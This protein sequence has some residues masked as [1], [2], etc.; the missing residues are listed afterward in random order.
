MELGPDARREEEK[1]TSVRHG[2]GHNSL[3]GNDQSMPT[4]RTFHCLWCHMRVISALRGCRQDR[5]DLEVT[6]G[7]LAG[8]R[9]AK[10][11]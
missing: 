7:Y 8:L 3:G 10:V 5:Q 2:V 11:T 6:R 4:K 9:L 1:P